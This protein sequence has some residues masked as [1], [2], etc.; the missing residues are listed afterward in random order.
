MKFVGTFPPGDL[1]IVENSVA[2]TFL[3]ESTIGKRHPEKKIA[4]IINITQFFKV[5]LLS[6]RSTYNFLYFF[7]FQ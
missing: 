3:N 2:P 4:C 1:L 5:Y 6:M 7:V